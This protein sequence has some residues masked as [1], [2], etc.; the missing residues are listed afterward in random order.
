MYPVTQGRCTEKWHRG[1][2]NTL[3]SLTSVC[4]SGQGLQPCGTVGRVTTYPRQCAKCFL[5]YEAPTE[6]CLHDHRAG[7]P[8]GRNLIS[9]LPPYAHP[10]VSTEGGFS[11]PV[12]KAEQ[13]QCILSLGQVNS[14]IK[15]QGV[16]LGLTATAGRG[17]RFTCRDLHSTT[18]AQ[19]E[20]ADGSSVILRPGQT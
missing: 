15:D 17:T 5:G 19:A 11:F 20:K 6:L 4:D 9:I 18:T 14:L 2:I 13:M 8:G 1:G 7:L 12:C 10:L 3:V 16:T